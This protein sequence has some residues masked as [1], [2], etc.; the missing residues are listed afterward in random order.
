M[1]IQLRILLYN[2]S[3]QYTFPF[4]CSVDAFIARKLLIISE[5]YQISNLDLALIL[6]LR[7]FVWLML[8]CFFLIDV[9]TDFIFL[10]FGYSYMKMAIT[11]RFSWE[12]WSCIAVWGYLYPRNWR[13]V[14]EFSG[15][16][17]SYC[18]IP[19]SL[20]CSKSGTKEVQDAA[21]LF[22]HSVVVYIYVPFGCFVY[23]EIERVIGFASVDL[24]PL[25]WGFQSVCGWYNITD[26]SGQCHG[27]LK[28][29]IT[30]LKG[31]QHLRGQRKS[32]NE[33]SAKHTSVRECIH[34]HTDCYR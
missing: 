22:L 27:Q 5:V 24:S 28:V 31:V 7:I 33:E 13:F 19:N 12:S 9:F 11:C 10:N 18:L 4:F 34:T 8:T 2:C 3:L 14:F 6:L 16:R 25:L 30:P 32:V 26:F 23:T 17:I 1:Y 15:F 29:S 21:S 20:S